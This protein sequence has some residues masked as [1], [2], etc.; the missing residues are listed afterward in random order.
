MT[1]FSK[2]IESDFKTLTNQQKAKIPSLSISN[3]FQ[4]E[5]KEYL[6]DLESQ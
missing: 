2:K 5:P 6:A 1:G 3:L 4:L